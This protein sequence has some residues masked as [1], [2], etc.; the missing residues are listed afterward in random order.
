[1]NIIYDVLFDVRARGAYVPPP[2]RAPL[3]RLTGLD[4]DGIQ[5]RFLPSV[6]ATVSV[7]AKPSH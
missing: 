3:A 4:V 7:S 5:T 1:M 6:T 2:V